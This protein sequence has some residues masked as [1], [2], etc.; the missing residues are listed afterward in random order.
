M[1]RSNKILTALAAFGFFASS[2]A[3]ISSNGTSAG[4]FFGGFLKSG[5]TS[6]WVHFPTKQPTATEKGIKEYWCNCSGGYSFT[7][8]DVAN[9]PDSTIYKTDLFKTDDERYIPSINEIN[10]KISTLIGEPQVMKVD[11]VNEI[12]RDLKFLNPQSLANISNLSEFNTLVD[13]TNDLAVSVIG[14]ESKDAAVEKYSYTPLE[15]VD[16]P[17]FGKVVSAEENCSWK[18]FKVSTS[19]IDSSEFDE[20]GV[21]GF[22]VYCDDV[23]TNVI[24]CN[25]IEDYSKGGNG[26]TSDVNPSCSFYNRYDTAA[27]EATKL[28]LFENVF[29]A[30]EGWHLVVLN[31]KFN[32]KVL[33]SIKENKYFSFSFACN[34]IEKTGDKV[35][36]T[37]LFGLKDLVLDEN[38]YV[39]RHFRN[40]YCSN[41]PSW[42]SADDINNKVGD[43]WNPAFTYKTSDTY[44]YVGRNYSYKSDVDHVVNGYF[45]YDTK[46]VY[47]EDY[48]LLGGYTYFYINMD[49]KCQI[50]FGGN[51]GPYRN[52]SLYK[53]IN[54]IDFS[55]LELSKIND[56]ND[57]ITFNFKDAAGTTFTWAPGMEFENIGSIYCIPDIPS[58]E[59][60]NDQI[61]AIPNNPKAMNIDF[62][63]DVKSKYEKLSANEKTQIKN[64]NKINEAIEATSRFVSIV[65]PLTSGE[66]VKYNSDVEIGA[67]IYDPTFGKVF[68]VVVGGTNN[69]AWRKFH[70]AKADIDYES[71]SDV[72]VLGFYVKGDAT[73][74]L[75]E[76]T[77]IDWIPGKTDSDLPTSTPKVSFKTCLNSSVGASNQVG[78][79]AQY[80]ETFGVPGNG[81]QLMTLP[82]VYTKQVLDL[83]KKDGGL[84]F[85]VESNVSAS[86]NGGMLMSGLFG[87]RVNGGAISSTDSFTYKCGNGWPSVKD[88]GGVSSDS[89]IKTTLTTTF[90]NTYQKHQSD[91]SLQTKIYC[92][93]NTSNKVLNGAFYFTSHSLFNE[94]NGFSN[95][96]VYV[97]VRYETTARI[98]L[99]SSLPGT[100]TTLKPGFNKLDF[101]QA[102]IAYLAQK[103]SS[104]SVLIQMNS[105][106]KIVPG[107]YISVSPI[108]G[109][110]A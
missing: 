68:N 5:N 99:T 2:L 61:S 88:E 15:I 26:S 62:I 28:H 11:K 84:S 57:S 20:I 34:G 39:Y 19:E 33:D 107:Q 75:K 3:C 36:F 30:P 25:F 47:T 72:G 96:S 94:V 43:V 110:V 67:P 108:F 16:D 45:T 74:V 77:V 97:Y 21:L 79:M 12:H 54:R 52:I 87:I 51:S 7:K 81:W 18:T 109:T 105:G 29:G 103:P 14:P 69:C 65:S 38:S 64:S 10:S 71:L 104:N 4:S 22:Y 101:T 27:Y 82:A 48:D 106:N 76:F 83:M 32:Q 40:S 80:A 100:Y 42:A 78:L 50:H 53:G 95:L 91:S 44:E 85:K 9:I 73:N 60:I 86:A 46:A 24:K 1:K 31:S 58:V 55:A 17:T 63:Q 89:L 93:E 98:Y 102:Q 13:D 49:A 66:L 70:F 59:R 41:L 90:D 92:F 23:T 56:T 8:P 35:K 37:S 6:S